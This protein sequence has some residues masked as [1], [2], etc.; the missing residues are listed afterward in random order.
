MS[1]KVWTTED[2]K[3]LRQQRSVGAIAAVLDRP[4]GEVQAI[5]RDLEEWIESPPL[6]PK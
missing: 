2:L 3:A 5:V 1:P 4:V 6:A